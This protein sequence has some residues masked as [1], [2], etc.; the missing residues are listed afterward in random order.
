MRWPR[1]RLGVL[2]GTFD[3]IH[4]GHLAAAEAAIECADLDQVVFVPT[5][6]PPHRPRA[7]A[8]GEQRL[9]MCRFATA[10]DPRFTVSNIELEREGP[11]Y[12]LDTLLA[13]R[14]ANPHAEMFLVLGWDAAS[15]LRSWYRPDEVLALA[16]VIVITRPG[17][18][19]PT[20]DDVKTAGLDPARVILCPRPTPSVSGSDLRRDLMAGRPV[21]GRVPE[22]V[23]HYI[24]THH[25]YR[26]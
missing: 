5:G 15:Q 22:A 19:A 20:I 1:M 6:T 25:I 13:L 14:G 2:G 9:E 3:P 21:T 16:P 17:R 18:A 24:A 12:T 8:S 26:G 23:E 4:L 7:M 11:S 10:G